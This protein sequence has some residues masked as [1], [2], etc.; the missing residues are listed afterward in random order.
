MIFLLH[1]KTYVTS[2]SNRNVTLGNKILNN[3][4]LHHKNLISKMGITQLM[5]ECGYAIELYCKK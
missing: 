3:I 5:Y 4:M 2:K 1:S